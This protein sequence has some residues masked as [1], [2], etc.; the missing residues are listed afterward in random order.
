MLRIYFGDMK[1][2]AHGPTWF[3]Y[4]YDP[5]WFEDELV[6]EMIREVD[7]T[8]Y[9]DGSIFDSPVLG[10]IPP[11]RLSG[12]VKTLIVIYKMPEKIFDATSCGANCA[13]MLLTIGKREDVTVNLR[14]YM[15][16]KSLDPFEIEILN[17]GRI[18]TQERDYALAALDCLEEAGM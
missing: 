5:S 9:V 15:P 12:G 1:E 16:M 7:H 4:N 2:A 6:Q 3:K 18:V 11:E 13:H 8:E 14:Y 10:K 17:T